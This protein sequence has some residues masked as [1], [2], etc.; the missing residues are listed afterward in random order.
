MSTI[1][2]RFS[3]IVLI[4]SHISDQI[5]EINHAHH[6]LNH[7]RIA[8]IKRWYIEIINSVERLSDFGRSLIRVSEFVEF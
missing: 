8:L 4:A 5:N 1:N 6:V 7:C 3:T 2:L